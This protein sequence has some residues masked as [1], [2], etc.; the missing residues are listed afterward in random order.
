MLQSR[1]QDL[2][3]G[4]FLQ[5]DRVNLLFLV[6]IIII[7]III[8]T[9]IIVIMT[10]VT[11]SSSSY[12]TSPLCCALFLVHY[13]WWGVLQNFFAFEVKR[14]YTSGEN[15]A[16]VNSMGRSRK[17]PFC[18]NFVDCKCYPWIWVIFSANIIELTS[19]TISSSAAAA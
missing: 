5:V 3:Q 12:S 10:I 18:V 19:N 13:S 11:S 8:I 17:V 9:I 2:L 14:P 15:I 6:L 16:L 4:G 7:I 1:W